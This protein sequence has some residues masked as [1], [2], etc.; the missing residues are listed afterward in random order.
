VHTTRVS[1]GTVAVRTPAWAL[2][3]G[4]ITLRRAVSRPQGKRAVPYLLLAPALLLVCILVAGVLSLTWS[5]LHGYDT[6]LG[7]SG[8]FSFTQYQQ[9][10]QDPQFSP[11]LVRTVLM[12]AL[13]AVITVFLSVPFTL[14]L[15]RIRSRGWRLMLLIAMFTPF[16][17]GDV[18]RT[19]GWIVALGPHGPF[20]GLLHLIGVGSPTLLGTEWAI[21]IGI[22]QVT[23]PIVVVILLPAVLKLDPELEAAAMTLGAPRRRVFLSVILP[24]LKVTGYAALAI[25]FALSMSSYADPLI[26][27]EGRNDFLANLLQDRYL[28]L[29]DAPLGAAIGI[30]LLIL[31][32]VGFG[33]TIALGRVRIGRR[34]L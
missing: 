7:T 15:G 6:F 13:T 21:G 4:I 14:V 27:G 24:Q 30:I 18:T 16:L 2:V 8:K 1:D 33:A 31:V 34:G 17:T 19:F 20:H 28:N 29:G 32:A 11:V 5:S 9:A 22:V 12:A 3:D 25:A 23:V 26:L 10:V